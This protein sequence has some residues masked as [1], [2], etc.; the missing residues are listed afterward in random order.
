M[1]RF[2]LPLKLPEPSFRTNPS[3]TTNLT[4]CHKRTVYCKSSTLIHCDLLSNVGS[5][6]LFWPARH[7]ESPFGLGAVYGFIV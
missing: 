3:Q 4:L 7:S 1:N 5:K 2:N 6:A